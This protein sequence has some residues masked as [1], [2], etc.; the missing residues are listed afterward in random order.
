VRR[1]WRIGR[2]KLPCYLHVSVMFSSD[3]ES[4][5]I[6]SNITRPSN[7]CGDSTP[8]RFRMVGAQDRFATRKIAKRRATKSRASRDQRI[9]VHIK[10]APNVAWLPLASVRLRPSLIVQVCQNDSVRIPTPMRP[11][12]PA[13]RA[14]CANRF[15]RKGAPRCA[16][17][18][19]L[20]RAK[21]E[22]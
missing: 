1:C 8:R 14:C 3:D 6:G 20:L 2:W 10:F 12:R 21:S 9:W 19:R 18:K 11:S 13:R 22:C 4:T 17:G 5:V 7:F 15:K 16:G